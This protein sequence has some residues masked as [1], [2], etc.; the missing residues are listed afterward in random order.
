VVI[1]ALL[2]AGESNNK[3][4]A[5]ANGGLIYGTVGSSK[6]TPSHTTSH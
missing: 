2:P 3:N 4:N 1:M 5:P 6:I